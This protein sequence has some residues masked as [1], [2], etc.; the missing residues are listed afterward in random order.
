[1]SLLQ[2]KENVKSVVEVAAEQSERL[3][4]INNPSLCLAATPTALPTFS[5]SV[6]IASQ[7]NN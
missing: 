7:S 5:F 1:M 3:F 6:I 2:K 4:V